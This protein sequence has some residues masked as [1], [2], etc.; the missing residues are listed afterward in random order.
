MKDGAGA[1]VGLALVAGEIVWAD[2]D[3]PASGVERLTAI[4][5]LAALACL[6]SMLWLMGSARSPA[7]VGLAAVAPLVGTLAAVGL[8]TRPARLLAGIRREARLWPSIVWR[9][10]AASL[11]IASLVANAPRWGGAAAWPVS[12]VLGCEAA[13]CAWRIGVDVRP[14]RWYRSFFVSALHFGAVGAALASIVRSTDSL[15]NAIEYYALFHL[16]AILVCLTAGLLDT[17]RMTQ[18]HADIRDANRI[19][20]DEHRRRAHWLHDDVSSQLRIVSLKVQHDAASPS[21]VVAL[22]DG[23]DHALRLRQLDE[24]LDSG[25]ARLAEIIQPYVRNAQGHGATISAVPSFEDA[26]LVVGTATGRTFARAAAIF[27]ANAIQ[28]GASE[29]GFHVSH[30]DHEIQLGVTDNAGGFEL[31]QVPAGRALWELAHTVGR[32]RL[33]VDRTDGTTAVT[34]RIPLHEGDTHGNAADR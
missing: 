12:I 17:V 24:L 3:E 6:A 1:A 25:N 9:T 22:I 23:L 29:I 11:L 30:D 10:A 31:A 16:L 33:A 15:R 32:D 13:L 27:T 4:V 14:V 2:I 18:M 21:D 20:A 34:I 8:A 7:P 19:V 28:A 5:E 26:S